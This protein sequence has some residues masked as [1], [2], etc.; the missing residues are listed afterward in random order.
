MRIVRF[1][2]LSHPFEECDLCGI[3][4]NRRSGTAA[5]ECKEEGGGGDEETAR[6]APTG[7]NSTRLRLLNQAASKLRIAACGVYPEREVALKLA[8]IRCEQVQLELNG[9]ALRVTAGRAFEELRSF[10]R[11]GKIGTTTAS[12]VA[13]G[14][15]GG[16]SESSETIDA[17]LVRLAVELAGALL[18]NLHLGAEDGVN[19]LRDGLV[20]TRG[21]G[22]SVK[23][24]VQLMEP[25]VR[26]SLGDRIVR[27]GIEQWGDEGERGK[28][29]VSFEAFV[30]GPLALLVGC[31]VEGAAEEDEAGE[32]KKGNSESSVESIA[33]GG[34]GRRR[35]V[36]AREWATK[37]V[38]VATLRDFAK[39]V[40]LSADKN[41]EEGVECDERGQI[42]KIQWKKKNLNGNMDMIGDVLER[43]PRLQLLDLSQNNAL[44]GT[45]GV[46]CLSSLFNSKAFRGKEKKKRRGLVIRT[47][48]TS[49]ST[50]QPHTLPHSSRSPSSSV[51]LPFRRGCRQDR[52]P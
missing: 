17:M 51:R 43:M 19:V 35:L 13:V 46:L 1:I 45:C 9:A 3:P 36:E 18:G 27:W 37:K 48:F 31:G 12:S 8:E 2:D 49:E 33:C 40:G 16:S 11:D 39:C 34:E 32:E 23:P 50:A 41:V 21:V 4:R 24:P 28:H 29:V 7:N 38:A 26:A 22:S 52:A 25:G 14:G 44:T 5:G 30:N 10:P 42:T 15:R 47:P 6:D 20:R